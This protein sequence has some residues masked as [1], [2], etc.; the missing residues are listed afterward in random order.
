[1]RPFGVKR[2]YTFGDLCRP[3]LNLHHKTQPKKRLLPYRNQMY[4]LRFSAPGTALIRFSHQTFIFHSC[5][6]LPRS[7]SFCF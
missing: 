1:M 6:I 2:V 5:C 3:V 4:Y 7:R